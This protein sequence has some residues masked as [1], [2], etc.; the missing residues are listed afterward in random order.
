MTPN[1]D[2]TIYEQH[3]RDFPVRMNT[4]TGLYGYGRYAGGFNLH[5]AVHISETT[6]RSCEALGGR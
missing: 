2:E 6:A 5:S 1:Y 3:C 4:R